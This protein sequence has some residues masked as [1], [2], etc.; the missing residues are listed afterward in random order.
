MMFISVLFPEPLAPMMAVYS[1]ST[2]S[3]LI[4]RNADTSTFVPG[5]R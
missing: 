2:N 3:T 1:P 5:L 4:D